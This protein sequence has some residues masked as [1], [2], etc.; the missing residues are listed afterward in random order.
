MSFIQDGNWVIHA[1]VTKKM[2]ICSSKV[3]WILGLLLGQ[4][5]VSLID[6]DIVIVSHWRYIYWWVILI[7]YA[8]RTF[9]KP[10]DQFPNALRADAW[11]PLRNSFLILN[12]SPSPRNSLLDDRRRIL[13][14]TSGDKPGMSCLRYTEVLIMLSSGETLFGAVSL[15]TQWKNEDYPLPF[16]IQCCCWA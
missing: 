8:C 1:N 4:C 3:T 16:I 15:S 7:M 9:I 2:E 6:H 10:I 13:E 12:F 14:K 11:Q 5:K